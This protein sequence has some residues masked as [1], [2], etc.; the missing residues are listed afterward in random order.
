M[1]LVKY[2]KIENSGGGNTIL[3]GTTTI[4]DNTSRG[5]SGTRSGDRTIWGQDDEGDNDIDGTATIHGN[6]LIKSIAEKTYD[7]DDEDDDGEDVEEETG[8]G[9]LDVEQKTTT[10]ELEVGEDAYIKRHLFINSTHPDH[11]GE[12]VCVGELIQANAKAIEDEVKRAKEEESKLSTAISNETDRATKAEEAIQ[13]NL[14][15]EVKRAKEEE[16]K[17]ST[18]ISN[19]EKRAKDEEARI[20][21][22]ITTANG[23]I[24]DI[25][26]ELANGLGEDAIKKLIEE[27]TVKYEIGAY[28]HPI[29]LA[30]G[31]YYRGANHTDNSNYFFNGTKHDRLKMQNIPDINGGL[32]TIDVGAENWSWDDYDY[33]LNVCS[34]V[35]CQAM[36]QK[37]EDLT[38][39]SGSR[40]SRGAHWFEAR[41]DSGTGTT[42]I[43]IREFSQADSNNDSW[44]TSGWFNGDGIWEVNIIVTGYFSRLKKS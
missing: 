25:Q 40:R 37:T 42:K 28:N 4:E 27:A 41:T 35:A 9:N 33:T 43:Y 36:S 19:E 8:G 32:M 18:A 30:C 23:D 1:K 10:K 29:V 20:E 38:F 2:D 14:D 6:V 3:G 15:A 31:K 13:K 24:A 5:D 26:E 12:K 16:S 44:Q 17:L 7:P 39:T 11:S 22:L 34:V 21:G